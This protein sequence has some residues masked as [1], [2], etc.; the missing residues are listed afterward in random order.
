[1]VPHLSQ[2]WYASIVK[3]LIHSRKMTCIN[4]K[5]IFMGMYIDKGLEILLVICWSFI[6]CYLS[7]MIYWLLQWN[8]NDH[9][10]IRTWKCIPSGIHQLSAQIAKFMGPKWGPPGS[11]RPHVGPMMAPWTLLSGSRLMLL[12]CVFVDIWAQGRICL[13]AVTRNWVGLTGIY[14]QGSF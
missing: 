12:M 9:D 3:I 7:W 6:C 4:T 13:L 11:W 10:D 1:M 14:M 8:D 2:Y 5:A